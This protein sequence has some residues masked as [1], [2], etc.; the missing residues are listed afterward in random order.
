MRNY[1]ISFKPEETSFIH[2]LKTLPL[3]KLLERHPDF[4]YSLYAEELI[5]NEDHTINILYIPPM[6]KNEHGDILLENIYTNTDGFVCE[7]IF[8]NEDDISNETKFEITDSKT[9][10]PVY[11]IQLTQNERKRHE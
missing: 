10:T 2:E 7:N 9:N 4:Q 5:S 1:T 11:S 6:G 8:I 3:D